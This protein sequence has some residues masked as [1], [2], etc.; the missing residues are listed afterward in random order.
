LATSPAAPG[1]A[2]TRPPP[3]HAL[4]GAGVSRAACAA[5]LPCAPSLR[6]PLWHHHRVTGTQV[7]AAALG[8]L[9][10]QIAGAHPHDPARAL[11]PGADDP[12]A[13]PVGEVTEAAGERDELHQGHP[14]P[15][16]IAP[17]PRNLP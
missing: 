6:G 15:P 17:R 4:P 9:A 7:Q 1:A 5:G 8:G 10:Q 14:A 16:G 3:P 12:D 13:V 2:R 11:L